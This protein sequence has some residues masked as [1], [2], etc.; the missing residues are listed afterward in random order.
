MLDINDKN[1]S[2]DFGFNENGDEDNEN[3]I[4]DKNKIQGA[5]GF[6]KEIKQ[7][8]LDKENNKG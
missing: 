2:E 7:Q 6:Q 5:L 3:N 1:Q 4:E 8:L